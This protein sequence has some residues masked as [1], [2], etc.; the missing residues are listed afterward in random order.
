MLS[1]RTTFKIGGKARG[2][3]EPKNT[4]E[5]S[6]FLKSLSSFVPVCPIG[7]GSNL[8]VQDGTVNRIFISLSRP[9]FCRMRVLEDR[10][11]A[12]AGLKLTVLVRLLTELGLTGHEFLAGIPGTLGGALFMNAGAKINP[13]DSQSYREMKDIVESIAVLDRKGHMSVLSRRAAKFAYRRSALGNR[14]AVSCVLRLKKDSPNLVRL[15]VRRILDAR[16]K[17][18]DLAYP[19]AGSFF[20][21]PG[22]GKTAGQLIDACGLKGMIVGGACVSAK[23]ANFIVNKGGAS[24]ADVIKLMEIIRKCVYNRFKIRLQPEVKIVA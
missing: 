12:G 2:W 10:V 22:K 1:A 9:D 24:C 13:Q 19:S 3:Y 17:V 18:Q 4:A 15:R 5:L 8:L 21:N 14:I 16:R 23:H 6:L 11:E 7:S 20:K